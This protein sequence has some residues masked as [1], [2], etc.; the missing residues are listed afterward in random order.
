MASRKEKIYDYVRT[1]TKSMIDSKEL[2]NNGVDALNIALTLK[3]DRANVSRELNTLWKEGKIIKILGRPTLYVEYSLIKTEYPNQYIPLVISNGNTLPSFIQKSK[4]E[5]L[6]K[7]PYS[8]SP[9]DSIIG[10]AGSLHSAVDQAISAV[11]YPP[12]GLPLLLLGNA[13]V[14]KRKFAETIYFYCLKNNTLPKCAQ[15]VIVN[16]QDYANAEDRFFS[17]LLGY[18][19][20]SALNMKSAPGFID[21]ANQGIVYFDGIHRL[22]PKSIDL[23]IDILK[24]ESYTQIGDSHPMPLKAEFIASVGENVQ[25]NILENIQDAFPIVISLP[26]FADRHV[27]EK[28]ETILYLFTR[29]SYSTGKSIRVDKSILTAFAMAQYRKNEAQ[30]RGE[31][32]SACAKALLEQCSKSVH[33]V[34]IEFE[35]LSNSV[36]YGVSSSA[37]SGELL[38]ALSLYKEA[39]FI[40]EANGHCDALDFYKTLQRQ[41]YNE[42]KSSKQVGNTHP[43]SILIVCHGQATASDLKTY[44]DKSV[45]HTNVQTH[46][47]N[48][49]E[50]ISLAELLEQ[51]CI[52]TTNLNRGNGVL[53]L[54][55]MEPITGMEADIIRRT[56]LPCKI[57][58][59]VT[60]SYLINAID[61]CSEGASLDGFSH[62]MT[63]TSKVNYSDLSKDEFINHLVN[64]ILSRTLL[65][66]NPKKATDTLLYSLNL[67]LD[68]LGLVY[69]QEIAVKYLSH[70]VHM[71]ERILRNNSLPY[72]QL[73]QF[74]NANH[75]LMDIIAQS[76]NLVNDTFGISVPSSEVAYLAEIFLIQGM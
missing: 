64:D 14:G 43:L 11:S 10:F 7:D 71:I 16:C 36:L 12:F 33:M 48:Y 72:Y 26:D 41:H 30:L 17:H 25:M 62:I 38:R 68:Q 22:S 13:G 44:A 28:I 65:F 57:I 42:D 70:G 56:Q 45:E 51:M 2:E 29:E 53:I 63:T 21:V 6:P 46:A 32:Q 4:Q 69:S 54:A 40:C 75:K 52:A 31:I 27:L 18:K 60:L 35:H 67:I 59:N 19:K 37:S 34:T 74:T 20:N 9:L 8:Q 23:V 55:D 66:V 1:F 47:I 15:F 39:F 3:L 58:P 50:D 76:L 5:P 24:N 49:T 61:R 73:K